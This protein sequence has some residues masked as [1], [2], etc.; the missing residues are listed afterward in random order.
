MASVV[1]DIKALTDSIVA[2]DREVAGATEQRKQEHAEFEK[3]FQQNN[4]AVQLVEVAKNRMQKFYNPKLYK[5]PAKRELTE[6]ERIT[7][8]MGGTLAPTSPPA[9]LQVS[10]RTHL[11]QPEAFPQTQTNYAKKS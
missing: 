10:A 11:R 5:P 8:N 9:L 1:D 4:A 2:L 6:E 3:V 7:V